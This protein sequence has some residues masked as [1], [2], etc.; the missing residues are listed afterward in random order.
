MFVVYILVSSLFYFSIMLPKVLFAS[1]NEVWSTPQELFD[2]L[3]EEFNFTLDPC[4][5]EDNA[6]C[7]KFYTP[8]DDGLKQDWGGNQYSAILHTAGRLEI[9]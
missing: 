8:V 6:K 3:N 1:N 9:G 5:I 7:A 2:N 4:A